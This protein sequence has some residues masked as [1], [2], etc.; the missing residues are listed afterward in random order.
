MRSTEG[1]LAQRRKAR[2]GGFDAFLCA[3]APLREALRFVRPEVG[4]A[5]DFRSWCL[6]GLKSRILSIEDQEDRVSRKARKGGSGAF[7]CASAPLREALRFVRLE[8]GLA[9]EL[10]SVCVCSCH[11]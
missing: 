8:V 11:S 3:S 9:D 4:L 7:L 1:G 5:E 6:C 2:K 10:R